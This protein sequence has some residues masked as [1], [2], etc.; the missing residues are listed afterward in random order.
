MIAY[1]A[2][3]AR[4]F[5]KAFFSTYS[6]TAAI[7][8]S[9]IS[10]IGFGIIYAILNHDISKLERWK[11]QAAEFNIED[12]GVVSNLSLS[13][14]RENGRN[15]T[16]ITAQYKNHK[17]TFSGVDPDFQ[18]KYKIGDRIAIKVHPNDEQQFVL[19]ELGE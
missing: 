1:F 7:T 16:I 11:K 14:T 13:S 18:T 10:T 6:L 15:T 5:Y 8:F 3:V 4:E 2:I 12:H 17:I 9:V 19:K